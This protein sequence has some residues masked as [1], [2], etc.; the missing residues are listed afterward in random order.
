MEKLKASRYNHFVESEDGKMLAFNA[1][2]CGLAEMDRESYKRYQDL[3]AGNGHITDDEPDELLKNLKKGGF[4]IPEDFEELDALRAGHYRARFGNNGF[5][6]TIVPTLNCNFAC[7]YCYEN[8]EIHS[9]PPDQGGM[10]SQEVC[11]N[12]V[13]LCEKEI[14]K[15]SAFTATWY[16]GE[17]MLACDVI[18]YLS[19]RFISICESQKSQYYAGMITN[20][21]LLSKKNLDFLIKNKI[22][23]LQITIDGPREVHNK[24]RPLKSG[25]GTFDRILSNLTYI[26]DKTPMTV[27]IRINIDK[28]NQNKIAELLAD[29]KQHGLHQQKNFSIYFGHTVNYYNSCPDITSQCMATEEFSHFMIDA[30]KLAADMGFIITIL[31]EVQISTCGAVKTNS[32][33][34]E[35]DGSV[36]NCWNTIGSSKAKTGVVR[37]DGFTFNNNHIKWLGWSPF[38]K[39]CESCSI[40]PLC[41]GGPYNWIYSKKIT[42]QQNIKCATWKYNLKS[43]LVVANYAL[44]KK[45][46]HI[47]LTPNLKG[48]EK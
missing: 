18:G 48:G 25:G 41:M 14:A 46:L 37:H 43:M 13:K 26:T 15:N 38:T 6:L 11:D 22:T 45:L 9:L 35:P 1:L 7:D 24:R 12:I 44:Q 2:S 4:L 5:G 30:W 29:L 47:P 21:Y 17:P 20:G 39:M 36:Q 31:P 32:A 27:S 34:I 28:R 8:K 10:M 23:F 19:E 3:A 16:G 42:T 33:V 40:L